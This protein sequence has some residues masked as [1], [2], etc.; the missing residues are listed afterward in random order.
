MRLKCS[1]AR[2]LS[3]NSVR[4]R[5]S[6]TMKKGEKGIQLLIVVLVVAVAVINSY[7]KSKEEGVDKGIPF[8]TTASKELQ[9]KSSK[10]YRDLGCR[11]C[12]SLWGIR[13]A[14][15]SVPSPPLDG[16]G[17]LKDEAWLFEYLSA[18]NPQLIVPSRLKAEYQMP[19][20]A[21]LP[22]EERRVL[23]K[24]LSSLK[25][26]DWYLEDVRK[27]EYEKLTGK[28]YEDRDKVSDGE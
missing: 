7:R 23:A 21:Y 16:I 15:Q 11:D 17:S 13:N 6:F 27:T 25:V 19:S 8:Y 2:K 24:Y 28:N 5:N 18:K 20:Y 3:K 10:L 22:E 1:V 26:E 12:H 4:I 9:K 14:M